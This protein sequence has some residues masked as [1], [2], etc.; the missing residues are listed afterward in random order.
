V[1][2]S[3]KAPGKTVVAKKKPAANTGSAPKRRVARRR[4][5]YSPWKEPTYADSTA[6][7]QVSGDDPVVRRAAVE[8]LGPLNG[9]V[10]VTDAD[11]GRILTIVNQKL[12][13]KPGFTPCS[14]IKPFVG[15]AGLTEGLVERETIVTINRWTKFN[16]TDAMAKS[17]NSYFALLGQRLGFERVSY[18]AKLFGLGE[19]ATTGIED[20]RPGSLPRVP[21]ANGGVGMMSSFGEGIRMSPLQLAAGMGAV[22][23]GG[24]LYYLQ[25]P[26]SREAVDRLVPRVKRQ[27]ELQAILGEIKPGLVAAV[28]HG[29]ARLANHS[30]EE[31]ILGKT[32]TCT[33]Q[34]SPTHLGWFGSFNDSQLNRIVVV[35][36]LTGGRPIN[37]PVAADVAGRIYRSLTAAGYFKEA[38]PTSPVALAGRRQCCL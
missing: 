33:D 19:P 1:T 20:E 18:H 23:N 34:W 17:D 15:M 22:A 35:V 25:Y 7:D 37:G 11:S 8:A 21:P 28:D 10:V 2:A 30:Q 4:S 36:L 31:T 27:L 29:T 9:S 16:M 26:Q 14:T 12:A 5:Y 3:T 32:G 38:R 6:G 13:F 24:T